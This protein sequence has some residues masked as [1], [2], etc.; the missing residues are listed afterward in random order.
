MGS[1]L[2]KVCYFGCRIEF[3]G[4]PGPSLVVLFGRGYIAKMD[5]IIYCRMT[6][7]LHTERGVWHAKNGS[8]KAEYQ[9]GQGTDRKVS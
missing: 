8:V 9:N 4:T 3:A 2:F 1:T 5:F 7:V 6:F